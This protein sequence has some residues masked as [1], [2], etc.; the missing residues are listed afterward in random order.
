MID[1]PASPV[2]GQKFNSGTGGIYTFDGVAWNLSPPTA[3]AANDNMVVN[4]GPSVSQENGTTAGSIINTNYYP[5]DQWSG[6]AAT[7]GAVTAQFVAAPAGSKAVSPYRMRVTVTTA[8]TSI[9]ATEYAQLYQTVEMARISNLKWGQPD[10]RN[11]VVRFGWKSPAG[12]YCARISN[13]AGDRTF[14]MPFTISAAQANTETEQVFSIPGDT[15][16]TWAVGLNAGALIIGFGFA[17]GTNFQGVAGWQAG[18]LIGTSAISNG[19]ATVNNTFEVWDIGFYV[20]PDKTG[21]PPPFVLPSYDAALLDCLR[22]W[23]RYSGIINFTSWVAAGG[24]FITVYTFVV[25]MR[26]SPTQAYTGLGYS[27]SNSLTTNGVA[28]K[29]LI[30][31]A[32]GTAAGQ[33]YVGFTMSLSARM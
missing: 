6:N 28:D 24:Q 2:A 31:Q 5:A 27:N 13:V 29:F 11:A 9:A 16:G 15:L 1:F 4:P 10:A 33:A 20:D 32:L 30:V 19:L 25:P 17:A 7:T 12:T 18:N 21:L 22:Y 14:L 3:T 23:Q 26:V 8:D